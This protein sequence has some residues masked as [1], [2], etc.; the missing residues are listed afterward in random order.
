MKSLLIHTLLLLS[1]FTYAQESHWDTQGLEKTNGKKVIPGH[2]C[3]SDSSAWLAIVKVK[4]KVGLYLVSMTED[5]NEE[6]NVSTNGKG[7]SRGL[8]VLGY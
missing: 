5:I 2:T 7:S 6:G 4:K 8:P 3:Y 1:V